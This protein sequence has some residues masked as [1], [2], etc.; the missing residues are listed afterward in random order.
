M[1]T[2]GGINEDKKWKEINFLSWEA[3]KSRFRAILVRMLRSWVKE[4]ILE[5]PKSV[6]SF[7]K[8]KKNISDFGLLLSSLFSVAWYVHVG[9]KLSNTDYTVKYIGSC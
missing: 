3:L 8:K 7:W 6:I 9:E 1:F 2:S 4:N 5:L